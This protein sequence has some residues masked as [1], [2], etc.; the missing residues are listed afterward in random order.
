LFSSFQQYLAIARAT[1]KEAY[2]LAQR[3]IGLGLKIRCS[4]KE[5]HLGLMRAAM[6]KQSDLPTD[7]HLTEK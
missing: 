6:A 3:T 1:E 2:W 4:A 7:H 5:N